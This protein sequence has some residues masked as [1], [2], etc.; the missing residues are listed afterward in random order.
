[1]SIVAT[2]ASPTEA[3][4]C[5][6]P[7]PC[8][9]PWRTP[10]CPPTAWQ[11]HEDSGSQRNSRFQLDR[12]ARISAIV[13]VLAALLLPVLLGAK[14]KTQ[15][16]RCEYNLKQVGLSFRIWADDHQGKFPMQVSTNAGGTMEFIGSPDATYPHFLIMSNELSTPII[17]FCPND[18]DNTRK[19]SNS[20]VNPKSTNGSRSKVTET[21]AIS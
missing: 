18:S 11:C 9:Q 21:S 16:I 12:I 17:L 13:A 8:P 20:F 4:R 2:S 6:T 1:M 14:A 5:T 19:R 15:R 3:R 7:S 10:A